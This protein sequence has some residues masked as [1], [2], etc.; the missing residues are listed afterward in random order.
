MRVFVYY[1]SRQKNFSIRSL[2]Q[3]GYGLVVGHAD[4]LQITNA[5]FKVSEAGRQ[6]VLR[7]NHKNVHAGIEGELDLDWLNFNVEDV[8]FEDMPPMTTVRY[9]PYQF[10]SFVTEPT[11]QPILVS[12]RVVIMNNTVF[13]EI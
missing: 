12:N 4:S 1:N 2:D 13:A 10:S 8:S 5:I 9:N 7:T 3:L 11:K 6:R